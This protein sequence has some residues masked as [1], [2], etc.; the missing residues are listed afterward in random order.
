M[1]APQRHTDG[2]MTRAVRLLPAK[3]ILRRRAELHA[4]LQ[5]EIR[6]QKMERDHG[7][8]PEPDPQLELLPP[9]LDQLPADNIGEPG[10]PDPR[11]LWYSACRED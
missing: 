7:P 4:K 9:G 3:E 1:M 6:L 8:V 2:S 10:L 5:E 11:T